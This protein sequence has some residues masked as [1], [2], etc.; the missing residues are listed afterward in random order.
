MKVEDV[1]N[2]DPIGLAKL[3]LRA[4]IKSILKEKHFTE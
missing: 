4:E 2:L 3:K 1:I